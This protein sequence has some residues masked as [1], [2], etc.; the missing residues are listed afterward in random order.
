[1]V[2]LTELG[3]FDAM[4]ACEAGGWSSDSWDELLSSPSLLVD[5]I[6]LIGGGDL[7]VDAANGVCGMSLSESE[8][9]KIWIKANQN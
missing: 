6:F 7:C 8:S 5:L 1:M 9:G 3:M 2:F 4:L